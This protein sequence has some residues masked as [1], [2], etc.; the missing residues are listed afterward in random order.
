MSVIKNIREH[1]LCITTFKQTAFAC[2][3]FIKIIPLSTFHLY[4]LFLAYAAM[5]V[6]YIKSIFIQRDSTRTVNEKRTFLNY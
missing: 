6:P 2:A 3:C 5:R 4:A 1:I